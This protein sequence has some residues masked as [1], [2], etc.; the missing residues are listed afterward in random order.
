MWKRLSMI[1]LLGVLASAAATPVVAGGA[2]VDRLVNFE[3]VLAVVMPDDFPMASL[4]RADCPR[5]IRVERPDG[6][7]TETIDYR[8]NSNPV[9]IPEFQ[10]S[11]PSRAFVLVVPACVWFSDYWFYTAGIDVLAESVRYTVTPSGRVHARSEYPAEPLN[12]E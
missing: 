5:L 8:L 4:M 6:S 3:T 11:P 12:C 10:G 7:A 9:M 1:A 2:K